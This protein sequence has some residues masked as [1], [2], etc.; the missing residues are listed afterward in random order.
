MED[1]G[2]KVELKKSLKSF[3]LFAIGFGCVIGWGWISMGSYWIGGAGPLAA[4]IA[5]GMAGL[6][7]GMITI[8]YA[9]LTSAMPKAGGVQNYAWRAFGP[10]VSF[11]AAWT[12]LMCSVVMS[13]WLANAAI[14]AIGR[15][16]PLT[17][18]PL[19]FTVYGYD[20]HLAEVILYIALTLVMYI[21]TYRGISV[22]ASIQNICVVVMIAVV[23]V[24]IAASFF[25]GD[26]QN[27]KPLVS[28]GVSGIF[29]I[30][31]TCVT[32]FGGLEVLP[33]S[34]EEST[35]PP[36]KLGKIICLVL[37]AAFLWFA[38]T[39]YATAVALPRDEIIST[40]LPAVNA[41][42]ALFGGNELAGDAIIII[43]L[44][45]IL[46]SWIAMFIVVTR[47]V[48]SMS[49]AGMLPSWLGEL[50][51]KYQTPVHALSVFFVFIVAC[52]F[53]GNGVNIWF[54]NASGFTNAIGYLFCAVSFVAL[55]IKAPSMNRPYNIKKWKLVSGIAIILSI[56]L[57]IVSFPGFPGSGLK[58]PYEVLT[59]VIWFA[60][61]AVFYFRI[62]RK[63]EGFK[64]IDE[65]MRKL[66]IEENEA[67]EE[68]EADNG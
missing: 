7:M 50:H 14:V 6:L 11:W 59:V 44:L 9:E 49:R 63:K 8:I 54:A 48:Y 45:G 10:K 20:V 51:P 40:E 16:F 2:K 28:N 26:T 38:L 25:K 32:F 3:D 55:K 52:A 42:T 19:L 43:G 36:K 17:S 13:A 12:M 56:A 64:E 53:L 35:V 22:M 39:I 27:L 58:W 57:L 33:Q 34:A 4:I 23:I 18:S 61:G 30:L 60:L 37:L 65:H 29:G 68:I 66:L 24:F 31:L 21:L 62:C 47:L 15:L 5:L 67:E 41:M 1:K 46:T